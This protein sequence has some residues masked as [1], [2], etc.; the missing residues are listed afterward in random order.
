MSLGYKLL[1]KVFSKGILHI[2]L[3]KLKNIKR[4]K[5]RAKTN[6]YNRRNTKVHLELLNM[7]LKLFHCLHSIIKKKFYS[8]FYHRLLYISLNL[9][10]NIEYELEKNNKCNLIRE[11]YKKGYFQILNNILTIRFNYIYIDTGLKFQ[12]FVKK[13]LN[14]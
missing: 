9:N 3:I 7:N 14:D 6:V 8:I 1:L 11:G 12:D 10:N 5:K 2:F 4:R 13:I